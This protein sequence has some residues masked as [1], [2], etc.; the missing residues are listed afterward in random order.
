M[1]KINHYSNGQV[2]QSQRGNILT[3]FYKEG[4]IKAQGPIKDN[5]MDGLWHFYRENGIVSE[6]GTFKKGLK[7]GPWVEYDKIGSV[8][9]E[10]QY[11]E[12]VEVSKRLYH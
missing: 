11:E 9:A 4:T 1:N 10:I 2:Q 8:V 3:Q 12:G 6:A 5:L 7:H